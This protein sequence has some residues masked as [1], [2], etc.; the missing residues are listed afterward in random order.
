[1]KNFRYFSGIGILVATLAL[2]GCQADEP[3]DIITDESVPAE[4]TL[5]LTIPE[6]VVEEVASRAESTSLSSLTVLCYNGTDMTK[7]LSSIRLSSGWS[8]TSDGKVE[9]TVP[10]HKQ[11]VAIQLVGNTPESVNLSGDLTQAFVNTPDAGILW[12]KAAI[13]D[14]LTK[15]ASSHTINLVRA[16]AKV[17]ATSSASGFTLSGIAVYGTATDGSVAPAGLN[18]DSSTPN[19]KNGETYTYSSGL[20]SAS[21]EIN[22]F[23]TPKDNAENPKARIIIRGTYKGVDGYY[24][25]AF[26][27]RSGSGNSDIAN[28]YQYTPIDVLRNHHYKVTVTAVRAEGYRTLEE[29]YKGHPDNRLTVDITDSNAEVTSVVACRDYELG[30]SSEVEAGSNDQTVKIIVVSSRPEVAGE[31]RVVLS[32]NASWIKTEG[33]ALPAYVNV[34]M[35]SSKNSTGYRYEINVPIDPNAS[36]DS[37]TGTITVRSGDLSQEITVTQKYHDYLNDDSRLVKLTMGGNV[38]ATHYFNWI[39]TTVKGAGSDAF[40]QSG[41]SRDRGLNFPAVP[42]YE[43]TYEIAVLSG[44]KS[45]TITSNSSL[46]KV[47]TSGNVYRVT[48]TTQT[49]PGIAEGELTIVNAAG[50]NIKYPLY[51]CGYLHELTSATASYQLE[52]DAHTGWYYYE[53][54]NC[55]GIWTTD[56]NIGADS[57]LPYITTSARLK[58]NSGATGAYFKLADAKSTTSATLV[59]SKLG[60]SSWKIPTQDQLNSMSVRTTDLTP[61][62]SERTYIAGMNTQS[63][64]KLSRVYIP[65]TGYFEAT[66]L[67]YETHANVWSSTL[68]SGSQGFSSSSPEYGFWFMY[69]DV[70]NTSTNFSN[71][72]IANGSSGQAPNSNSVFKYMP[73]RPVW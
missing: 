55:G 52:G 35:N 48:M 21:S 16:N 63:G 30:V 36:A 25:V 40:Y 47:T 2:T 50:V 44:D 14:I 67:K 23:E 38:V 31:Q 53:V 54:V 64:S 28:S 18:A 3:F 66:S 27:T 20:K 65:H 13:K 56:R 37:R 45:A 59:I 39:S 58:M 7:P 19:V 68:V 61:T 9:V 34:N 49:T 60:M 51:R 22:V 46:F 15:P 5:Q 6:Y 4:L 69:L 71:M 1:M 57:G 70:Y 62:G 11:T 10:L 26:R 17:S 12:G 29:A 42:A 8:V 32:D 41:V 73:I 43:A 24:P 72:R 33:L